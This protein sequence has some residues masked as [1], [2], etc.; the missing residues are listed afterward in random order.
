MVT[1]YCVYTYSASFVSLLKSVQT[2]WPI[3]YILSS[4]HR[5]LFPEVRRLRPDT[6]RPPQSS[7]QVRNTNATTTSTFGITA[8]CLMK[9]SENSTFQMHSV[10]ARSKC[11]KQ[12]NK[13]R[14]KLNLR[15]T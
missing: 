4:G 11:S 7:A 15:V 10:K 14:G 1:Q 9:H 3:P 5:M 2:V 6:A 13:F 8:C 12:V